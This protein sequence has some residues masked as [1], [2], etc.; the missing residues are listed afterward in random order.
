MKETDRNQPREH[1]FEESRIDRRQFVQLAAATAGALALPGAATAQVTSERMTDLYQF[2]VNHTPEETGVATLVTFESEAGLDALSDVAADAVT[3]TDP[4]VAAHAQ[5]T[6][7]EVQE[8]LDIDSVAELQF[9][10]G[11]NPFWK[12]EDYADGVFPDPSESV[13]FIHYR[14]MVQG[15]E[16]LQNQHSD[17]MRFQAIGQSP[18]YFNNVTGEEEPKD[19]WVAEIT[20]DVQDE[21]SF[22]EKEKVLFSLSIHGNE[23]AGAEAGSRFIEQLLN[24]N[25]PSVAQHLDDVALIFLYTNPDGWV[26]QYPQYNDAGTGYQRG[27]AGV[28]DTN[29]SYPT[30]GWLNATHVPAEPNGTDLSDD[31]PGIDSDVDTEYTDRV[32]DSLGIVEHFRGYENLNYGSDLHG[33]YASENM[34]EGLLI[35]DQFTVEELHDL[36]EVNRTTG[37]R[38]EQNLGPQLQNSQ[39]LFEQLNEQT[40]EPEE[41]PVPEQAYNYGTVYDT[42]EYSTSG[43]L[44][45][46]MAQPEDQGGLGMKAMAHEMAYS[47]DATPRTWG[48]TDEFDAEISQLVDLFVVGYQTVIRTFAEHAAQN[49]SARIETD[50]ESTAVATTDAVARSSDALIP[51]EQSSLSVATAEGANAFT[52]SVIDVDGTRR[53]LTPRPT[54]ILGYEQRPYEVTPFAFFDHASDVTAGGQDAFVTH[55]VE[56]IA[57]G[58]LVDSDG[59]LAQSN[60]VVVH[61]DG[62]ENQAYRDALDSFVEN[63]GNLV[64]TDTGVHLVGR[65]SNSL[66]EG[67]TPE[68]VQTTQRTFAILEEDNY[69]HRLLSDTREFNDELWK[70]APLGYVIDPEDGEAPMTLVGPEAFTAAGGEI[71]ARTDGDVSAGSITSDGN[72]GTGVHVIGSLLPPAKQTHLHPFGMVNYTVSFFGTVLLTNAL[73]Y[74]QIRFVND[75]PVQ[76]FGPDEN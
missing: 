69:P 44:V 75:Q 35:N 24:G 48:P 16:R 65:L 4:A 3:T 54:D 39:N 64:L 23:R 60:L 40:D 57:D 55:S 46:W 68:D 17:R 11:A 63:G 12:L 61:D 7:E 34:I 32:P 5:L 30:V 15:M 6:T 20:N 62:I 27:S 50:G 42:L 21:A 74:R 22:Q 19:V 70:V 51:V 9:A 52:G 25:E 37:M 1:Q 71:A 76:V 33:M 29:R 72:S 38:L 18:G 47:N 67:I 36:Y 58:A 10:P 13:G 49:Q 73:G 8:V 45:S 59:G 43:I 26:A 53:V 28:E 2:A 31:Y 41:L 56:E 14:E 66:V